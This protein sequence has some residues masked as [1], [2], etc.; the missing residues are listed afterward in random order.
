MDNPGCQ[1]LI[2]GDFHVLRTSDGINKLNYYKH[3]FGEQRTASMVPMMKACLLND[4]VMI[5][6]TASLH[7]SRVAGLSQQP[8]QVSHQGLRRRR[9]P[10]RAWTIPW[11]ASQ[12]RPCLFQCVLRTACQRDQPGDLPGW[13]RQHLQQ[14]QAHRGGGAPGAGC[15]GQSGG[16]ALQGLLHRG[17]GQPGP[18]MVHRRRW[19]CVLPWPAHTRAHAGKVPHLDAEEGMRQGRMLRRRASTSTTL[20]CCARPRAPPA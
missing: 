6:S 19:R 9:L 7:A 1:S 16:G 4:T 15:A 11:T 2:C 18:C 20:G 14:P 3:K 8:S 5:T 13:R 12:A 17:A 10:R